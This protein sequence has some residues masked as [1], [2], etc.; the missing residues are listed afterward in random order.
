MKKGFLSVLLTVGM[1]LIM[2]PTTAY[3]DSSYCDIC[4]KRVDVNYSNY[5]YFDALFHQRS[6]YCQECGSF[7]AKSRSEHNWS[8]TATCTSGQTCTVCGGTSNPLGHNY[9]SS[10]T[11]EPTCTTDGVRTYV[12]KNDSSHTYTEPIPAVAHDWSSNWISDENNHWHKCNACTETTAVGKH[13]WNSGVITTSPTCTTA[14]E[15]TYT[16]SACERKK[17]EIISATGHNLEKV[18][19][20]DAG[21]TEDGHETYWRC[22][23][24]KKLFSDAAGTVEIS[25]P[26][27]IKATGHNLEKVEKKDAGCTKDGYETYWKCNTCKK[28]FSDEA[29]T[30][31][32]SNPTAIKATGHNLK[33]V[34]KKDATA[35]EEGN[36]TYWFCDKCNKY[37]SDAKAETEIKKEDTM[38]AKLSTVNKKETEAS[39]AKTANATKVT[40]TTDK[41]TKSSPKTGDSTDVQLYV[42]LML[43][44]IGAAAGA[45]AKRKLKTQ[46]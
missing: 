14:G 43:V 5:E 23:T 18:E 30:V 19:K 32:I 13:I 31:E 38:L 27:A 24:C 22:Q 25:N 2:L 29:G 37:F 20:K 34:E 10:V 12:C 26:T 28:L 1:M 36:S 7:V 11:T 35:T 8:G 9:E 41:T 39:S 4:G 46:R 21:C 44:S 45:G 42:I 40:S 15:K 33:K 3:A 17:T 16:C 6:G